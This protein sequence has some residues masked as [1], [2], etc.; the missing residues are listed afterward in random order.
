MGEEMA[1]SMSEEI[2]KA[3]DGQRDLETEYAD[4]VAMRG[5]LKG[6]SN[7][8]KL[9]QTKEDIKVSIFLSPEY[10]NKA[11]TFFHVLTLIMKIE[12]RIRV[13]RSN[14]KTLPAAVRQARH[15]RQLAWN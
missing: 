15:G 11:V 3:M 9:Q 14:S 6:I 1:E 10:S 4:L 12:S 2:T 5:Q 13:E 7:K 8:H